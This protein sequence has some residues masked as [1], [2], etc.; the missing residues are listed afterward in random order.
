M[1]PSLPRRRTGAALLVLALVVGPLAAGLLTPFRAHLDG[2]HVILVLVLVVAAVSALG[3]RPAGVVAAAGTGLAYDV[4][5]TQPYGSLAI[6]NAA[7]LTTVVL[8]MVVGVAIE[9][10]SG[11]AQRQQGAA[12]QRLGYLS[13]LRGVAEVSAPGSETERLAAVNAAISQLLD[14]DRCRFVPGPS[15]GETTLDPDGSVRRRGRTLEV[16]RSGLPTDDAIA[17][18]VRTADG[19]AAFFEVVAATRV[20]RPNL[21]RRHVAAL[22]AAL[23]ASRVRTVPTLVDR[24]PDRST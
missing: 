10:L 7:D 3:R 12:A 18:P 5:W 15:A 8:L 17:I 9:Q 11:W 19:S 2:A 22:L 24:V 1:D 13:A 14:A 4:F 16:D 20:A 6:A 21:E 23:T